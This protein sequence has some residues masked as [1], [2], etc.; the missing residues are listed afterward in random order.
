MSNAQPPPD[1][2]KAA[3]EYTPYSQQEVGYVQ[4][5]GTPGQMCQN[6]RWF[7][8]YTCAIVNDMAPK[9][10]VNTGWCSEWTAEPDTMTAI[11]QPV[12][13]LEEGSV[14][15]IIGV[16]PMMGER[17]ADDKI[18]TPEGGGEYFQ[19][20]PMN[21]IVKGKTHPVTPRQTIF[22]DASGRRYM[23]I[24]TSN[25]YKDRE[26]EWIPAAELKNYVERCWIDEKTF[27]SDNPLLFW[28]DE[29]LKAGDIIWADMQ[30]SFLIE[31]ARE[32]DDPI[33]KALWDYR[34]ANPGGELWGASHG[35]RYR[36]RSAE[37]VY[38]GVRKKETSFLPLWAAANLLTA[39]EVLTVSKSRDEFVNKLFGTMGIANAAELLRS[40]PAALETALASA[41]INS[42]SADGTVQQ[43]LISKEAAALITEMVD[44]QSDMLGRLETLETKAK[45]APAIPPELQQQLN[46]I[47]AGLKQVQQMLEVD[48]TQASKD[49]GTVVD[50]KTDSAAKDAAA[51]LEQK[52]V[53]NYDPF[54]G[55]MKIATTP[56]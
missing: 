47:A 2:Q 45:E 18:L 42:K 37:G 10:I 54:F 8:R 26:E 12:V 34:E 19:T 41:G 21:I 44:A 53:G 50:P 6:C 29:R 49:A 32:G 38:A 24:V 51:D 39:S 46:V 13:I 55:D 40:G 48:P 52:Q 1:K 25:G 20:P 17:S 33:S 9:S 23:F 16:M 35:F 56:R 43:P 15:G 5:S 27:H 31:L 30:G 22:K 28:H 4:V 7:N 11:V 36:E 14:S 3:K